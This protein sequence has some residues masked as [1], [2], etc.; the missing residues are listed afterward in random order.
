M[1]SPGWWDTAL[2]EFKPDRILC[3]GYRIEELIGRVSYAEMLYMMVKGDLPSPWAGRLLEA[4]LVAACDA[5]AVS[6]AV[7]ASTMAATCGLTF[8][9]VIA[10]GMNMIGSIHGGAV[11]EAMEVLHTIVRRGE[12][13]SLSEAAAAVVREYA[14]RRRYLPGLGHPVLRTDPRT[15][16]LYQLAAEAKREGAIDGRFLAAAHALEDAVPGVLG[17]RLCANVDL[18]AAAVLCEVGMPVETAMGHICLSRGIGL[19]AH[20][21]E[22]MQRGGRLKGPCP[23]EHLDREMTYSGPPERPLPTRYQSSRRSPWC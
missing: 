16:R 8:S 19:M 10:T 13:A 5:G 18:G 12:E 22:E 1:T 4:V 3:R 11:Q 21:Y 7:S 14:Q 2:I 23:P 17:R 6:P 15:E 9:S 20:A